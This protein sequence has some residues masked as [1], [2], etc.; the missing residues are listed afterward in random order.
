MNEIDTDGVATL[1]A[2]SLIARL[3][4]S[5]LL[6]S[7][8]S[9]VGIVQEHDTHSLFLFHIATDMAM[10]VVVEGPAQLGWVRVAARRVGQMVV[11]LLAA[12]NLQ[13]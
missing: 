11:G 6:G 4:L 8:S 12:N 3:A 2:A 1:S 10:V 9:N 7:A 13:S 5:G